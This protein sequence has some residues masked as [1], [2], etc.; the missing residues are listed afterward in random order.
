[1]INI[2]ILAVARQRNGGTLLYTLSMIEALNQLPPNSHRLVVFTSPDN[3]EYDSLGLPIVRVRAPLTVF[4]QSLLGSNPFAGID[5]IL[6]PVHSAILLVCGRPFVFTLHDMQERYYPQ[7]F[8]LTV[9]IWRRLIN[10]TLTTRAQRV[11]CESTF[12]QKDIV[13]FIGIQADKVLVIPA[14][15]ITTLRDDVG[16]EVSLTAVRQKFDLPKSYVFYPAQFWPHKNHL[17]LVEA[18]RLV[19]REHPDCALVLTGKE[20]DEFQRVFD[21]VRELGML[22]N[23]RHIGYVERSELAALYRCATAA[24]IPTLFESISIPVYE[25]FSVGTPVCASNV[26]A[27]PEQIGDAGLMF[28]PNSTTDIAEK[29]CALLADP[30]L[31]SRLVARGQQRIASITHAQYAQRLASIVADVLG[32]DLAP[33]G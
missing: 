24:V 28:D 11:I 16:D 15:P 1:M 6:A 25:A 30:A 31:R 22:G 5:V 33:I 12:V 23:V 21:R 27:L 18:F 3:D 2:G 7:Y 14:P 19:L 10:W 8:S 17:R 26:V 9:R 32:S 29:I 20:R 13:R 4:M